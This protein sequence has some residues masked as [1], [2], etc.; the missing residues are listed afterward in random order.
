MI[1]LQRSCSSFCY[2]PTNL[3][4]N[5]HGVISSKKRALS[6]WVNLTHRYIDVPYK[7]KDA[8]K[9][10]GAKWD[11]RK[12]KWYVPPH[13]DIRKFAK[14]INVE[15][16]VSAEDVTE[17]QKLGAKF[18]LSSGTKSW[19]INGEQDVRLFSKWI[20]G[21]DEDISSG[22]SNGSSSDD[23]NDN[24][25]ATATATATAAA[26]AKTTNVGSANGVVPVTRCDERNRFLVFLDLE[27]TGLPEKG[28][29]YKE[30]G[31]RI[32]Q[33][34]CM[35]C[36]GIDTLEEEVFEDMIVKSD[37][38]EISNAQF[39]G[40]SLER[41]LAEGMEFEEAAN[42]LFKLLK[43][44]RFVIVHNADFDINMLKSE[45]YRHGL[46]EYLEELERLG[47]I[48]TMKT[49]IELVGA[50]SKTNRLKYPNLKEL[51][52]FATGKE[53]KGH[54]D[55][56][57]DVMNLHVAIQCLVRKNM[58]TLPSSSL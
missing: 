53:L 16:T 58:L 55:S 40:I 52:A 20:A 35:L 42:R 36:E 44:A 7:E 23:S 30:Y 43:Q 12:T 41:S 45:L 25:H 9:A 22:S 6:G 29:S 11:Y 47:I 14:W 17:V 49:T 56:K 34:S 27:T 3:P 21:S 46:T 1:H 2:R 5:L 15:L 39:H 13:H 19:Y 38:F 37:G 24:M 48:C 32:V 18:D 33:I 31:C 10:L 54:H 50:V 28:Q 51:Y 8:A 26:A 57:Y 4:S